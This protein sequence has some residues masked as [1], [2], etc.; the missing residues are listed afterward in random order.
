MIEQPK[1]TAISET[2]IVDDE[3]V[4]PDAPLEKTAFINEELAVIEHPMIT[5][6]LK[7]SLVHLHK[8]GGF[9]A[10]WRGL[11]I[12]MVYH[13]CHALLAQCL[14]VP[15]M[16]IN[17]M[18]QPLGFIIASVLLAR[19][20]MTWTHIM[21]SGPSEK[22][23]YRRMPRGMRVWKALFL[24]S[25]VYAVSQQLVVVLPM[26]TFFVTQVPPSDSTTDGLVFRLFCSLVTAE[27]VALFFLMPASVVLTRV[28][29]SLLPEDEDTIV[30]FDRTIN[31]A[32]PAAIALDSPKGNR[33]LFVQAWHTVDKAC[34]IRIMKFY[35]K[36]FFLQCALVTLMVTSFW[37][38]IMVVGVDN[39]ANFVE[40]M[41]GDW[42]P[43]RQ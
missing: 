33:A 24:P 34:R 28:E 9:R 36:Y 7:K 8:V 3:K 12:S 2:T 22:P 5:T 16:F 37:G 30:E 39:V 35:V 41:I 11:G 15:L 18:M 27:C 29:A 31:G 13:F 43:L 21:V 10:R 26:V 4:D 32:A 17:P 20:H 40:E 1:K 42:D 6:N 38:I 19:I 25:L 23:W 14:M